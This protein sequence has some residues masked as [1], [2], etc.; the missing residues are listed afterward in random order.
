[1]QSRPQDQEV[2]CYFCLFC[3]KF[4]AYCMSVSYWPFKFVRA[5]CRVRSESPS[6][7]AWK[8][9]MQKGLK[10]GNP[11]FE[12]WLYDLE[13]FL[14]NSALLG[15]TMSHHIYLSNGWMN[16]FMNECLYT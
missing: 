16:E 2:F 14:S 13:Y 1:M 15:Y 7:A 6:L 5:H 4:E 10:G 9:G 8:G 12:S 3:E 11:R